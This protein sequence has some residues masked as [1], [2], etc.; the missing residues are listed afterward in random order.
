MNGER[1]CLSMAADRL[2]PHLT[3]WSPLVTLQG[4]LL[5]RVNLIE[6]GSRKKEG[7]YNANRV[8]SQL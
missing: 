7:N 6:S 4:L 3:M 5:D 2:G 8:H 1:A